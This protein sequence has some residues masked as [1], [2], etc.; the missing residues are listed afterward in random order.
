MFC[1][2]ALSSS[3]W[4]LNLDNWSRC[5]WDQRDCCKDQR[6][7]YQFLIW[8]PVKPWLSSF[9]AT[10]V[11][12]FSSRWIFFFC[13][14][15]V[16]VNWTVDRNKCLVLQHFVNVSFFFSNGLSVRVNW[17][18][19]GWTFSSVTKCQ[20]TI[21]NVQMSLVA[22]CKDINFC[23]WLPSTEIKDI[24]FCLFWC[25]HHFEFFRT[26]EMA[27]EFIRECFHAD[28]AYYW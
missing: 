24:L 26:P 21:L 12:V 22:I 27:V 7:A 4:E 2:C 6:A 25:L 18:K 14:F 13:F 1:S 16:M 19:V 5:R 11:M 28:L 15:S 17:T 10:F 23:Q 8:T 3:F 9:C 20:L